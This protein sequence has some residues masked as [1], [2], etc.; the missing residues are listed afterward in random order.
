M[1]ESGDERCQGI[2]FSI[3]VICGWVCFVH[4]LTS[5]ESKDNLKTDYVWD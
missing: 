4:S 5:A 3:C 2:A 1:I